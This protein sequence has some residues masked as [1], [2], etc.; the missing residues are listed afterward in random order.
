[1]RVALL[2]AL[3]LGCGGWR[4]HDPAWPKQTVKET[5]G[6]ESLAPHTATTVSAS[7][8]SSDTTESKPEV[9]ES[10]P[11]A[12]DKPAASDAPAPSSPSSSQADEPITTEDIVI[13]IDD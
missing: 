10:K 9:S 3:C 7:E 5:D 11:A 8:R 1:M 4:G 6:G 12:T 13:E 2:F